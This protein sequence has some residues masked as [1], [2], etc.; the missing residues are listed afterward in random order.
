MPRN[1]PRIVFD[2]NALISAAILPNSISYRALKLAEAH[3]QLVMSHATWM[4]FH[5]VITRASLD[6][7]FPSFETRQDFILLISRSV[8]YV[9]VT[10]V[11][12]DCTDPKDNMLL[13]LAV[14]GGAAILVSGDDD[15][16]SMGHYRDIVILGTGDFLR[17]YA[18]Q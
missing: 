9:S 5:E 3:Y 10:S 11:I 14:D 12:T 13:E 18:E 6:R 1:R 17:K 4:E 16:K 7:Y 2:T 15:L 8:E